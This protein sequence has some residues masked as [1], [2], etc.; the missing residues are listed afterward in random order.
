MNL[1]FTIVEYAATLTENIVA[2]STVTGISGCK[3]R[4]RKHILLIWVFSLFIMLPVSVLNAIE[5]FSFLTIVVV[6]CMVT[7]ITKFTSKG[8]LLKR[9]MAAVITYLV[10][11]AVDYLV[12]FI[13]GFIT[14]NPIDDFHAFSLLMISGPTR[15]AFLITDKLTDVALY[16][17]VRRTFNGIRQLKTK[18]CAVLLCVSFAAY[19]T[20]S[21]LFSMIFIE[22]IYIMQTAI[23]LSW[24]FIV[25]CVFMVIV[26]F[27]TMTNHEIE[28]QRNELL[29]M[30]DELMAKNYQKVY[31]TQQASAR[32]I[33]DFNHHLKLLREYVQE[34][35]AIAYLDSLLNTAYKKIALCHS[36]NDVI[37]AIINCKA[38]EAENL[39]IQYRQHINLTNAIDIDP[40]DLCGVLAN[41]IDN[42]FDACRHIEDT[43]L[44]EVNVRIWQPT[45]NTVFFQVVNTV[46]ANPFIENEH[47]VSTKTDKS[48]PHGLGIYNIRSIVAKYQ[49]E[50]KNTYHDGRFVSTVFLCY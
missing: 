45:T 7:V 46:S 43:A 32:Q 23:M 33:H 35:K 13:S 16:F 15:T 37:D 10:I 44:R 29:R 20:M 48:A 12:F 25:A 3:Y 50:L 42:A 41:Q 49:G 14:E 2:I 28:R 38:S 11:H 6:L 26:I 21:F 17:L 19:T 22:S 18:Y 34:K 9:A 47:L 5:A 8:D 39:K 27:V 4:G 1:L 31:E 24:M 30:T 40:V 36:G